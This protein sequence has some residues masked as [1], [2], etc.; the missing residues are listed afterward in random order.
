M[1]I[2]T[3]CHL[4]D[5][6]FNGALDQVV[7]SY[8]SLGVTKAIDMGC[9]YK[10]SL[11]GK[12]LAEKYDSVYFGA[13]CHPSDA[14]TFNE[15]EYN[16]IK[17]LLSCEKCVAVGEIG[18]D[19][20]WDDSYKDV[21]KEVLKTQLSLCKETGLPFSLHVRDATLDAL[22]ILKENRDKII[23]GGVV[24]CF[25]GSKE[26][27]K[28]YMDLGLKIG[29][30]GPISF[31]NAERTREVV[32]YVPLD[33]IVT[34]TDCPYLSPEPFRGKTNSPKNIPIIVDVIARVKGEDIEKVEEIVYKNA[35]QV[36]KK[37]K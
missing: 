3:H 35:K 12:S 22:T 4:H 2:D 27:A 5:P 26:T 1:Y 21:Q 25:S 32:K 28:E 19:Y 37:I 16:G 33:F 17:S 29:F 13:G 14:K 15:E 23:N 6:K 34:E 10:T 18:L 9:C 20:Y 30:G 31:K 36:F 24:H 8:T 7:E 11:I